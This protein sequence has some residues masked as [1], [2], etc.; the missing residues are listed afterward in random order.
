MAVDKPTPSILFLATEDTA[1]LR[2]RLPMAEGARRAGFAVAVASGD[3]GHGGEIAKHGFAA[4]PWKIARKSLNPLREATAIGD[5]VRIFRRVTPTVVYA[6]GVKAIVYGAIA[7]LFHRRATLIA[8]FTGLGYVFI[9]SDP[10]ARILR[11]FIVAA[12]RLLLRGGQARILVQN[13]D[14]REF[15]N[16]RLK[17]G[18]SART[19]IIAGSGIDLDAYPVPPEETETQKER[20]VVAL[21]VGRMLWDKGVGELIAAARILA[22]RAPAVR[23]RLIGAP[24]PANPQSVAAGDL[25]RW[26]DEGLIDWLGPRAD[27]ARQWADADIAVLPSYREGLPK[28]LLEAGA[29]ARPSVTTDVAGCHDVVRDGVNGFLAPVRDVAAL[30][31]AIERL[32]ADPAARRRMGRE[33]RAIVEARFAAPIIAAQFGDYIKTLVQSAA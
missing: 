25:E 20:P 13:E 21:Y 24:D 6:G 31:D 22:V 28:S 10:K 32:A 9:G 12:L 26:R 15:L 33:A 1:F 7:R 23:V 27:I 18:T 3:T 11:F 16:D 14:D 5:L 30:A 4:L 8:A 17:I 29:C 2:H 19:V